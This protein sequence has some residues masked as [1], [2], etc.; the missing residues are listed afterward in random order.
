LIDQTQQVDVSEMYI[1]VS[2]KYVIVT[3]LILRWCLWRVQSPGKRR[4]V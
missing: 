3:D 2:C 4:R 1:S